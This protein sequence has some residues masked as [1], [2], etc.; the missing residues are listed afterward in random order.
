MPRALHPARQAGAEAEPEAAGECPGAR[1]LQPAAAQE[2]Q[3][4]RARLFSLAKP[5]S[6]IVFFS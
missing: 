4:G 1:R 6:E 3:S 2:P 5:Q